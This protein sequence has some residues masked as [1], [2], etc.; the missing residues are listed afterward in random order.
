MLELDKV[1][2]EQTVA[3][4]GLI[5]QVKTIRTRKGDAMARLSLE[6]Q[7]GSAEIVVFPELY[8]QSFNYLNTDM[9]VLVKGKPELEE[10]SAK[11]LASEIIPL[12]QVSQREATMM[13]LRVVIDVF[14]ADCLPHLRELLESHRGNCELRFELFHE[15]GFTVKLKPHP[16]LRVKPGPKLLA[17]LETICG[18][19][20][21]R[22]S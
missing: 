12:D 3:V 9:A 13:V 8:R 14:S 19:G 4:G 6:D 10:D 2:G 15:H 22:L 11:I 18:E 16:F 1:V 7:T 21:V 5:T 20:S 17:D